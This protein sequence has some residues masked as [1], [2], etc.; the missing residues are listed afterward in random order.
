MMDI[1]PILLTTV[2][3]EFDT[4]TE[5]LQCRVTFEGTDVVEVMCWDR[6]GRPYEINDEQA[7]AIG[8]KAVER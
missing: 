2:P 8:R 6:H 7:D 3:V 4:G 1:D 5:L